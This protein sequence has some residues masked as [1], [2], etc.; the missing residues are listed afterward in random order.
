MPAATDERL[1]KL[2]A[3]VDMNRNALVKLFADKATPDDVKRLLN[4]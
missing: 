2:C 1:N 3:E 4:R